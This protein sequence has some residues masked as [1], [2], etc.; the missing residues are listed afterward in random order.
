MAN[1]WDKSTP[2]RRK[3]L[4]RIQPESLNQIDICSESMI[5]LNT[6]PSDALQVGNQRYKGNTGRNSLAIND[7]TC[8]LSNAKDRQIYSPQSEILNCNS[9]VTPLPTRSE[10]KVQRDEIYMR[11]VM[12]K[13]AKNYYNM[14]KG[15]YFT[16]INTSTRKHLLNTPSGNETSTKR[17][18]RSPLSPPSPQSP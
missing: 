6:G 1:K 18:L 4:N 14:Q 3:I 8:S 17:S 13:T 16:T 15:L 7:I 12:P 9:Q 5:T 10:H 2:Q 11:A